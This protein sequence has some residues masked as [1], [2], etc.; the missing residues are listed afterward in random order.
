MVQLEEKRRIVQACFPASDEEARQLWHEIKP[1]KFGDMVEWVVAPPQGLEL[2]SYEIPQ[3]GEYLFITRVECCTF[4]NVAAAPG[5]GQFS[6]PPPGTAEW[7]LAT[8]TSE[9][10]L[11]PNIPTHLLLDTEEFLMAKGDYRAVLR[12][13]TDNPPDANQRFIRTLVYGYLLGATVA[14]RI[15]DSESTYFG[16]TP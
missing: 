8:A 5:F 7:I 13:Q 6:P 14:G 3:D 10:P 4:T 11:T 9:E 12:A 1:I 15:G 16:T 2:A